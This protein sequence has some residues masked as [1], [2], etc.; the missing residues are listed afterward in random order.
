MPPKYW[1]G[2]HD[3][4]KPDGELVA[5]FLRRKAYIL[6]DALK[7]QRKDGEVGDVSAD[8]P[9]YFELSRGQTLLLD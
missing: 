4:V 8:E 7:A 6:Q 5:P 9:N 2:T 3:E 1:V